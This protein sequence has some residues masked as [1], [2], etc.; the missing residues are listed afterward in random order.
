V[1]GR[2]A[3]TAASASKKT[4][5]EIDDINR[6]SN[7][8]TP[9]MRT[10]SRLRTGLNVYLL[11]AIAGGTIAVTAARAAQQSTADTGKPSILINRPV[12]LSDVPSDEWLSCGP[13]AT[14]PSLPRLDP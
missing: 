8:R 11:A 6:D 9:A 10:R 14:R 1:W 7:R 13:R 12:C 5:G 2:L 4:Q 3:R